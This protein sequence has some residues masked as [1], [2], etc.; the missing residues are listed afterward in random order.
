M[1]VRSK[2]LLFLAILLCSLLNAADYRIE[3]L[4]R[5]PIGPAAP[6]K[7]HRLTVC[8]DGTSVLT[9]A[10]GDL[11]V[12]AADGALL[13]SKTGVPELCYAL[14]SSCDENR[15]LYIDTAGTVHVFELRTS[16]EPVPVRTIRVGGAPRR[17]LAAAGRLVVLGLVDV[18]TPVALRMFDIAAGC[19]IGPLDLDLPVFVG[20]RP[21][22][23]VTEGSLIWDPARREFLC[24]PANPLRFWRYDTDGRFLGAVSPP[25]FTFH[26]ADPARVGPGDFRNVDRVFNAVR[27]PGGRFVL[28]ILRSRASRR[29]G[30]RGGYLMLLGRDFEPLDLEIDTTPVHGSPLAGADARGNLYFAYLSETREAEVIQARLAAR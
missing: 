28:H 5:T 9:A 12:I 15:R 22:R 2:A 30:V 19:E 6:G 21:Q 24:L 13:A 8:P 14:A 10:D 26:D 18:R 27:L 3:V 4:R 16:G 1:R 23:L 25:V 11:T 29:P 20:R 7:F 17:I